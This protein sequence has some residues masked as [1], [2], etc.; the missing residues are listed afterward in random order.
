[1]RWAASRQPG[2][3]SG[4]RKADSFGS[5]NSRAADRIAHAAADQQFGHDRRDARRVLKGRDAGRVV[6]VDAPTLGHDEPPAISFIGR[7]LC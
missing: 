6:R 1:M 2:S 4:S 7:A 3:S 5:R